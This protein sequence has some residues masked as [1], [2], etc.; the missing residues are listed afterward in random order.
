[1]NKIEGKEDDNI[2]SY[3]VC[4]SVATKEEIVEASKRCFDEYI[5]YIFSANLRNQSVKCVNE[6]FCG[7]CGHRMKDVIECKLNWSTSVARPE[8]EISKVC[9]V[10]K[11]KDGNRDGASVF[12]TDTVGDVEKG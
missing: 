2:I 11:K 4:D 1:M 6:Q 12:F 3:K 7:R 9:C 5:N 8:I 10:C